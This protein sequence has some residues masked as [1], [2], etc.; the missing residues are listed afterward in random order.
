MTEQT[1]GNA[2]AGVDWQ[3]WQRSWDR[4]QQWY[5][6]DREERFRMMLDT[7]EAVAGTAPTI[8]DLACGTGTIT[9]RALRR[10]PE[11][12]SVGVDLDPALLTLATGHFADD[13]RTRFVTADLTDPQWA[14][15]L[16]H[17]SFDAVVT[18]TALHWLDTEA[19]RALY[20]QLPGVLREGGVFLNADHMTDESAPRLN[21]S[22]AQFHERRRARERAAGA[23]DWA[24]WWTQLAAEPGL[25]QVAAERFAL[26][27]DP[28]EPHS[29]GRRGPRPTT[30]EWHLQ[31]LR[32][33]GFVEVRQMWCSASDALVAALR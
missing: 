4:Q 13:P 1:T 5:M 10:F 14:A 21:D 3:E 7:V 25:A 18:A 17:R 6:P 26:L 19:L 27:G 20:H 30:T 16:P 31:T 8:L 32:A 22:L 15:K 11:A 23:Q 2:A 9:D 12:R 33:A 24:S 28:R 29:G